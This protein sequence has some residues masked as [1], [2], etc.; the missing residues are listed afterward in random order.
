MRCRIHSPAD[1]TRSRRSSRWRARLAGIVVFASAA[2]SCGGGG[3]AGDEAPAAAIEPPTEQ[4]QQTAPDVQ[5]TASVTVSVPEGM[6]SA[7]FDTARTLTVPTGTTVALFARV[8]NARFM[9]VAPNGDLLV[10]NPGAGTITL[11]RPEGNAS[12][13]TFSFASGLTNPHDM[14][15]HTVGTTTYLYI[16][17]SNRIT[18]TTY[19]PGMISI[20]EPETVVANLPDASTPELNGSYGHQLK[21]IALRGNRLYVSI[22]STCNACLADTASDPIRGTIYEYDLQGGNR[23]LYAQGL[24]NAEGLAF[25]PGSNELWVTVNNRDNIAY[26]FHNDWDGDGTDDYGRVM[27]SYV[28]G[29]PPDLFTRV[30]DGGHYGWPFCNANPDTGLDNMPYDRDV[31]FNP[32]GTALDCSMITRATKGLPPHSAPLGFSFLRGFGLPAA[33]ENAMAVA[34][35]GCWNCSELNG[36][37][38]AIYP[39][40]ADGSVGAGI[41]L[42][43]GWV[44]DAK[45][46]ERWGRPVDVVPDGTGG[47]YV[48]DDFADAVYRIAFAS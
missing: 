39:L 43:T 24:R 46:R 15:F 34:L 21:N 12:S 31:E 26:P 23:R 4:P 3:S 47:L 30:A 45:E 19:T 40:L 44:T 42:V 1:P 35:H 9:A 48:S 18:R 6:A 28:D 5:A 22:A 13:Q 10:S 16:A 37:K 2:S 29:H 7:P 38:V 36:H 17:E 20:G 14:V 27:Q 32:D 8:T 41:D 33:F 25:K 11:L